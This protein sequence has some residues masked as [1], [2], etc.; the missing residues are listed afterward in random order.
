MALALRSA[1]LVAACSSISAAEVFAKSSGPKRDKVDLI[2]IHSIGGPECS[3]D[4]K[5]VI[6][7]PVKG[8]A[9]TW[10]SYFERHHELGIHWIIDRSG[11]MVSS[12]PEDQVANHAAG[13]N[14]TSIGIELVNTG[15]GVDPYPPVQIDALTRLIIG[16]RSRWGVV[17]Q[18]IKRHSDIDQGQ[19]L[20]CGSPRKVDPGANFPFVEVLRAVSEK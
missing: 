13:W 8:D 19:P 5:K 9:S 10:K 15:D 1:I 12:I 11:T 4:G 7:R 20:P 3:E 2:V 18:N 17:P 16:V 6:F 14:R